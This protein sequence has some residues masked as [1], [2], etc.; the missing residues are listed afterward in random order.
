MSKHSKLYDRAGLWQ[1]RALQA[2]AKGDHDRAGRLHTKSLQLA[3][4]AKREEEKILKK[5][6]RPYS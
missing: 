3:A 4:H 6:H 1:T 2:L 5:Q